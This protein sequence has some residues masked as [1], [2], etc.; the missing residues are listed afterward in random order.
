M[1]RMENDVGIAKT[2]EKIQEGIELAESRS[3]MNFFTDK[4]RMGNCESRV[5]KLEAMADKIRVDDKN[6]EDTEAIRKKVEVFHADGTSSIKEMNE[7]GEISVDK[8]SRPIMNKVELENAKAYK[9]DKKA[10]KAFKKALK[11][12]E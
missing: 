8:D 2:F 4:G 7:D 3:K 11:S 9:N 6:G 1:D 10:R 5:K 12:K